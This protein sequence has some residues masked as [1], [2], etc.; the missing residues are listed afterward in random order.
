MDEDTKQIKAQLF[1]GPCL[2]TFIKV[3]GD[4]RIMKCTL[5]EKYIPQAEPKKTDRVKKE[6]P[7]VL[8][9]W[10]LEK[11]GWRSF[12]LDTIIEIEPCIAG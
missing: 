11:E 6:N 8:A 3:D 5:N 10:D 1:E 9:V 2:V 12:R 4:K 7:D